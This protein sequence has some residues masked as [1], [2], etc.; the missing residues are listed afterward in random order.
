MYIY[1]ANC[2]FEAFLTVLRV[3]SH[4]LL[5]NYVLDPFKGL[6][7]VFELFLTLE[8]CFKAIFKVRLLCFE[9]FLA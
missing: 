1:Y 5:M 4:F 2:V 3:L 6:F 7:E 9:L 8:S